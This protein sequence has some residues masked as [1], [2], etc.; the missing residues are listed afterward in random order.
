LRKL[1]RYRGRKRG[2]IN[3]WKM[4]TPESFLVRGGDMKRNGFVNAKKMILTR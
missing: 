2:G 1:S 4:T 3:L